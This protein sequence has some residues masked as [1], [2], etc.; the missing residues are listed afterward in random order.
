MTAFIAKDFSLFFFKFFFKLN[1]KSMIP[2]ENFDKKGVM[3][4][5]SL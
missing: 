1:T 5:A 3:C 4:S 2:K